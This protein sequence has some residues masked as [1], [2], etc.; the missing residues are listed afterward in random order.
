MELVFA[1]HNKNKF[2]EIEAMLPEHITLLSLDDI[3]CTEDIAETADTIDGN[4]I[5][6]AEYVRHRYG[7]NCFADD[8][9]LEVEALAGAPGVYSARYAGEQKDDKANIKKLLEQLENKESRKARFK[10]VIALNLKDNENLF[11]GICKGHITETASGAKGFGYDPV[12]RPE[13]YDRTFAEMEMQEKAKISHRGK[14]FSELID[15]L[16]K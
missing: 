4:A 6:K 13:G 15:Y 2:K 14:A 7:Y 3:G 12:F 8:T 9:G 5:L 10:T 1:T 16:S 11:T